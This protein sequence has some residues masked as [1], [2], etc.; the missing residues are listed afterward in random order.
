MKRAFLVEMQ[1]MLKMSFVR[2]TD[3]WASK[4]LSYELKENDFDIGF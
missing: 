4:I 1:S 3:K 2:E